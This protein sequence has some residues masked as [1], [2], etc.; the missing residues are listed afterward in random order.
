MPRVNLRDPP[1]LFSPTLLGRLVSPKVLD[2]P[3]RGHDPAYTIPPVITVSRSEDVSGVLLTSNQGSFKANLSTLISSSA[4]SK[5]SATGVFTAEKGAVHCLE[6]SAVLFKEAMGLDT[7][8]RWVEEVLEQDTHFYMIVGL[9]TVTNTHRKTAEGLARQ[10]RGAVE[11]PTSL[12][13]PGTG[14]PI[15]VLAGSGIG[16]DHLTSDAKVISE[17]YRD[18]HITGVEYQKIRSGTFNFTRAVKLDKLILEDTSRWRYGAIHRGASGED[19]SDDED[20]IFVQLVD[21]GEEDQEV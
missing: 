13:L 17:R 18:E 6:N 9:Q 7:T 15:D 10:A 8:L 20:G 11:A 3:V 16:I 12:N 21:S 14:S 4:S 1:I 5:K 2:R 19:D